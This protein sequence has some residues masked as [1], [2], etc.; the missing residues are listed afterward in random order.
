MCLRWSCIRKE[1]NWQRLTTKFDF[2]NESTEGPFMITWAEPCSLCPGGFYPGITL[3]IFIPRSHLLGWLGCL[4]ITKLIFVAFSLTWHDFEKVSQSAKGPYPAHATWAY[5]FVLR[6]WICISLH[7]TNK[8]IVASV[9]SRLP[10]HQISVLYQL[11][12]GQCVYKRT[13]QH[14]TV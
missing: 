1:G 14:S 8:S 12:V 4:V 5:D 13:A 2:E 9:P 11:K 3:A 10:N 6:F 7:K